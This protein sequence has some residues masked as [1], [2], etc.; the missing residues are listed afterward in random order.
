MHK[1]LATQKALALDKSRR[2]QQAAEAGAAKNQ[3]DFDVKF[4]DVTIRINDTT[5]IIYGVVHTV[6]EATR[7]AVAQAEIDFHSGMT[8]DSITHSSGNLAYSPGGDVVTIT[9]DRAYNTGEEFEFYFW[10]HGHPTEGGLQAFSFDTH[11]GDPSISTLSEPYF[12][13]S[14]WPCKDRMDDKSDSLK[15]HIEVDTSLYVASNGI[16]DS[17][18]AG[19]STNTHAFHYSGRYPMATYLFSLAIAPFVIWEQEYVFNS[20]ADTMPI[21]HH[22]YPDWHSYSLPRWG[23]TPEAL[24][25]LSDAYGEYP[26]T[27]EKYG[28]ANFEW[29]GAM[30]HQTC[31]SMLGGTFGF[32]TNVIM[33]ELGHQWWGD[34]I[35][36]KSWEDIWLNEG[37]ASYSEAL[38]YLEKN[39]WASYRDYMN[40]MDYYGG[41]TV[42]C[43]DTTNVWRIFS[44]DLSYDK[45]AWVVHMLRHVVGED[46]FAAGVNAY[47]NSEFQYGAATTEDFKIVWEAA[48]GMELDWFFDE[49]IYNSHYPIYRY[50]YMDEPSDSEGYDIYLVARQVQ[51]SGSWIF[52]MPV[53]FYFDYN[54]IPDDTVTLVCDDRK[55]FF[56][57]NSP[58]SINQIQL[59]PF[60]W[61]LK[62][63]AVQSWTMFIISVEGELSDGYVDIAY[64][65]TVEYRGGTG[66][67]L[68]SVSDGA[69]PD[70]LSIGN[71][72]VISGTPTT[73][74]SFTFTIDLNDNGM[75]YMDSVV[76]SID[77]GP[78]P[79]CCVGMRGNV[80]C[81]PLDE[82]DGSDLSFMIDHLFISLDSV[83]CWEEANIDQT[84]GIDGIDLS[85]LIDNLFISLD[86]LHNCP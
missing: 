62:Q 69:F 73:E 18:T 78:T 3:V 20:L 57:F 26:F 24:E 50:Y 40:T 68:F 58:S 33:H 4:Y 27:D 48:T 37:W 9:L 83:C 13:R 59:D 49:W 81:D 21:V 19:S 32:S 76:L 10:Y 28:H 54:S 5:E 16:L 15:C 63:E 30:E 31:T 44:G 38:Y 67:W 84:G 51:G 39:G 1:V 25:I 45:G 35:T 70:G 14:W 52:H 34:M 12:A 82:V 42:W 60:D 36:C 23:I 7:S 47:Y 8:I 53:D 75:G 71:D 6:A 61:I 85:W 11:N 2:M 72:G 41:G 22:V 79:P 43:D 56:K 55:K 86:P 29:G 46:G 74:G 77:I 80:D 17:T 65:D 64:E 66:P